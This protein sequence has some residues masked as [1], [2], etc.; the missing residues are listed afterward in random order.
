MT[1]RLKSLYKAVN[2][3]ELN[4]QADVALTVSLPADR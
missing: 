2:L 4:K 1:K 3:T